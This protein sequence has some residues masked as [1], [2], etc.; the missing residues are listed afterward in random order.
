MNQLTS[1]L[2]NKNKSVRGG[3]FSFF[4][5]LH[6]QINKQTVGNRFSLGRFDFL[7]ECIISSIRRKNLAKSESVSALLSL[8]DNVT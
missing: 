5:L 1:D 2:L 3:K 6:V 7:C 8:I 4:S